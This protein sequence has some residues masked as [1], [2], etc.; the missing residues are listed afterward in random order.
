MVMNGN[1]PGKTVGFSEG[2]IEVLQEGK[3]TDTEK[4]P[5]LRP[6]WKVS[7]EC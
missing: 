1:T 3:N 5:K 2:Q 6:H 4:K 7:A